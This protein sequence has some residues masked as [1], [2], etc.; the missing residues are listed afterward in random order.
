MKLRTTAVSAAALRVNGPFAAL[1]EGFEH[2]IGMESKILAQ[3]TRILIGGQAK[4][5]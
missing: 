5:S 3:A 2:R 1:Q 4:G